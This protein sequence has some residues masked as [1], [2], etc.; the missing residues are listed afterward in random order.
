MCESQLANRLKANWAEIIAIT[1]LC[2]YDAA[3]VFI[4]VILLCS[5]R[6]AVQ[7]PRTGA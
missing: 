7:L 3:P 2:L 4:C 5:F 6:E 1:D